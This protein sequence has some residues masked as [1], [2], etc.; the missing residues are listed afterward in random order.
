MFAPPKPR[1]VALIPAS[2]M[3]VAATTAPDVLA[4]SLVQPTE[5][6]APATPEPAPGGASAPAPAETAPA[7]APEGGASATV[8]AGASP[9]SGEVKASASGPKAPAKRGRRQVPEGV[10]LDEQKNR[11][12]D[13]RPWIRRYSPERHLIEIGAFGGIYMPPNN[14]DLFAPLAGPKTAE[15][16]PL[17]RLGAQFGARI[18]YFPLRI[19]GFEAEFGASPTAVR[20]AR[21]DRALVYGVR[22]H[23][24][25]QLP[26]RITPF[27]LGGY[28]ILGIS[29]DA[30]K[31]LGSDIDRAGHYGGGLKIFINRYL[32][33][34]FDLRHLISASRYQASPKFSSHGEIN[35]GLS[36]VLGRVRPLP[37]PKDLDWDK[38]G[39]LNDV[40]ECPKL[41]GLPP[42]GCPAIDSDGDGFLDKKDKCPFEA[43][44]APDGC[45]PPDTDK[46][47]IIDPDDQCPTEPWPEPPGCPP[48]PDSDKDGIIDKI[49]N[50]PLHPESYNGFEDE[51]GCPDKL[52]EKAKDYDGKP[53][54]GIFFEFG[55]DKIKKNSA[56]TLDRAVAVLTEFK[57][58]K[59][60]ISGHTDD[61]GSREANLDLSQRR[62]DAVKRY[63][64]E[65]GVEEARIKTIGFGPDKPIDPAKTA[66]ARAKNR[67]IEFRVI[68]DKPAG[69]A[70]SADGDAPTD[71]GTSPAPASK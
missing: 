63:L 20:N 31:A 11:V 23:A 60:E 41:A 8:G 12:R 62:A 44:V 47:G 55:S 71:A 51:D 59:I 3:L 4:A 30:D 28:G 33:F 52:P 39:I 66:K 48:P 70:S 29:S 40:D 10:I 13:T 7:P 46:D 64:V 36:V 49:D 16:R 69:A 45:P 19:L 9:P 25:L 61:V 37:K 24:I 2:V 43:G 6:S 35:V 57:S 54:E 58:I 1:K 42:D 21:N 32:A 56:K 17:W 53:I 15:Q 14:H 38:D 18:A 34:R 65:K 26:F 50:C 22:G 5:A 27:L 67:R 68:I